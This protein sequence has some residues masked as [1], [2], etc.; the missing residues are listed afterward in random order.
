[1][2]DSTARVV[3]GLFYVSFLCAVGPEQSNDKFK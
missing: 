1:M 2:D 3:T